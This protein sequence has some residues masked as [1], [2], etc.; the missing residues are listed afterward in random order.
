MPNRV[1]RDWTDSKRIDRISYQA[2]VVFTR[3]L[4][5]MDDAGNFYR[6]A[7]L[8]KSLMFPRKDGIRASD[9]DRWLKELE[10]ADL[11]RSYPAKGDTFLHVVKHG[12][13]KDRT[14][15][16]YPR[17]PE[18]FDERDDSDDAIS[19]QVAASR[20]E[21]QPETKRIETE[22]KKETAQARDVFRY[23]DFISD[24][25]ELT[26]RKYVGD[27]TSRGHFNARLKEGFGREDFKKAIKNCMTDRFHIE[28][29]LK[30]LTPEFILRPDKLQ[31][32]LNAS[33]TGSAPAFNAPTQTQNPYYS[34]CPETWDAEFYKR[35]QNE[36]YADRKIAAYELKLKQNGYQKTSDG[37]IKKA[38]V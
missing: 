2:E 19:R 14:H 7:A 32:F 38:A 3:L 26:K 28:S 20:S 16:V 27:V 13:R 37:W 17:E 35:I 4:M 29:K 5:K 1:L 11:V 22:T 31:K 18:G 25:N 15:I 34:Y 6:D 8:V 9:I 23:E 30:H 12:Q 36:N 33:M 10:A 21:P 24:F